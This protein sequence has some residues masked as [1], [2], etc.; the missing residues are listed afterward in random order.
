MSTDHLDAASPARP[1]I[2]HDERI[3]RPLHPAHK[4]AAIV[5]DSREQVEVVVSQVNEEQPT[6][7]P[8]SQALPGRAI[9]DALTGELEAL[10]VGIDRAI[11]SKGSVPPGLELR[12]RVQQRA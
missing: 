12:E 4:E 2:L 10:E 6:G 3:R 9:T 7:N 8:G 1:K 11:A 5:I